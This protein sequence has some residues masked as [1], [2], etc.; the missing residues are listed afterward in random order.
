MV[1]VGLDGLREDY[2]SHVREYRCSGSFEQPIPCIDQC[3]A[4][5]DI[6]GYIALT[7]AGRYEDAV[8]LIQDNPFP[9]NTCTDL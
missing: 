7:G 9:V 8:R 6:P 5:V 4:H 2:L 1:L 3:P